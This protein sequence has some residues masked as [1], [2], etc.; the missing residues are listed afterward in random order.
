MEAE[1]VFSA[2]GAIARQMKGYET[3]PEQIEMFRAISQAIDKSTHLMVEAGTGVGKTFAYLVPAIAASLATGKAQTLAA[4]KPVIISTHTINLQE[5]IFYKD[6]PFLKKVLKKDFTVV[7]AKGRG[8][9]ICRRRLNNAVNYQKALFETAVEVEEIRRIKDWTSHLQG[10]LGSHPQGGHGSHPQGG[11]GSY[12]REGS[13]SELPWLPEESVWQ[14]I[15]CERDNCGGRKCSYYKTCFYRLARARIWSANLIVTNHALLLLDAAL[16]EEEANFLP[17]YEV[18]VI[19]EAH[20]LEKVAQ[21]HLG[22]EITRGRVSWL[23]N[24]LYNPKNN[25]GLLAFISPPIDALKACKKSHRQVRESA[26]IFFDKVLEWF[27]IDAPENGRVK[28]KF[29]IEN[30]LS[31][32]LA[33]LYFDLRKLKEA[34]DKKEYKPKGKWDETELNAYIK[35]TFGLAS[36]LDAFINQ[37]Q[38]D[39]VYW[40][41]VKK[42]QRGKP[43]IILK[44]API[45]VSEPLKALLFDRAKTAI[46][47]S[48]TLA[49]TTEYGERTP[50]RM[51]PGKFKRDKKL[52]LTYLK[53][54]LGVKEAQEV[55]LGSPFDYKKQVKLYLSRHMPN[56]NDKELF[57]PAVSKRILKYLTLTKGRAF[58]LF[59]SYDLMNKVYDRLYPDLARQGIN[60]YIQGRALP[61]HKMLEQ[62]KD[63][64]GTV[65]FGADSF[66]QGVDVPGQ[67][68]GNVIIT[69]LPFPVPSEPIVEAKIERMERQGID[70]F[71]NYF[72]PEAIIKLR[73]GFG[74]LIR[75]K[76]DRGIVVILDNRILTRQYG[77]FF[78]Q[79]LPECEI[80]VDN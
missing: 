45:S 70:S 49:T 1:Q 48:A 64:L 63:Q 34:L 13:R 78:L 6:I 28:A 42:L 15:C 80:V 5:Q 77:R 39:C 55:L 47:T 21:D 36:D 30:F 59:T 73:Q 40:V 58:V 72:M 79:S 54:V 37:N 53:N 38:S 9:Y 50:A 74:R 18:V 20:R 67:A 46:L 76:K 66:W 24:S 2:R 10:G 51:K 69:K 60:S 11:Q 56:P 8:N 57:E 22:L 16:R 19:D 43:R 65:I 62:L 41:E 4:G 32:A 7:L 35:R 17:N 52:G 14:K 33:R 71:M 61:R 27:N 68:L 29:F 23:L 12:P 31:P 26:E 44:S 25:K 75:T 3:R